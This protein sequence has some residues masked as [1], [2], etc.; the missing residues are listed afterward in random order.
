M[1]NVMNNDTIGDTGVGTPGQK[2]DIACCKDETFS[3]PRTDWINA[4]PLVLSNFVTGNNSKTVGLPSLINESLDCDTAALP[5]PIN[6]ILGCTKADDCH[7]NPRVAYHAPC[8]K[9]KSGAKGN[10]LSLEC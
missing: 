4:D 7:K 10:T 1:M 2:D 8:D 6:Q 3:P 9:E 5:S